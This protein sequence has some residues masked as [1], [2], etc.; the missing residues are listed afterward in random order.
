MARNS[1]SE[2]QTR[3]TKYR[4]VKIDGLDRG[5]RGKHF[6]LIQGILQQLKTIPPGSAMEIPLADTYSPEM[7]SLREGKITVDY[8]STLLSRRTSGAQNNDA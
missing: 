7:A 3:D 8:L 4:Q 1:K 5:R 2:E 6:D